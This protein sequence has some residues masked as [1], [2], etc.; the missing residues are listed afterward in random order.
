MLD[1]SLNFRHVCCLMQ[2]SPSLLAKS[3]KSEP[4]FFNFLDTFPSN[5]GNFLRNICVFTYLLMEHLVEQNI[6]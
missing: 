4:I 2:F 5:T 6:Y 1:L 3:T